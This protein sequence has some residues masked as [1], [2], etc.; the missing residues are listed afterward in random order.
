VDAGSNILITGSANSATFGEGEPNETMLEIGGGV[1]FVAKYAADGSLIWAT[2]SG[3][4]RAG[5]G[6]G[7]AVDADGNS[8]VTGGYG[9]GNFRIFVAEF[10]ADGSLLCFRGTG[11]SPGFSRSWGGIAVDADGDSV[12]TGAFS[13]MITFGEGESNETTLVT[14]GS[15]DIFVAKFIKCTA[16]G[17]D[18]LF[19]G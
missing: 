6:W 15:D 18:R 8:V 14:A 17:S 5:R 10:D 13:N 2:R 16:D 1:L 9:E 3:R 4:P 7:I 12:I 11:G 19:P